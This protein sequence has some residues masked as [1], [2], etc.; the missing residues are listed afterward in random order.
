MPK[1]ATAAYQP[2]TRIERRVV[3]AA[4]A[5][6]ARA[7]SVSP[8][9]VLVA[10]GW[11]PA[12]LVDGWRQGRVD[13]LERVAAV[14]PDKLAAALEHLATW[15]ERKGLQR[16]EVADVAATRDRRTLRYTAGGAPDVERAY[17]THWIRADLSGAQRERLTRRLSQAPDL[18][19]IQPLEEW[20]CTAC[21]DTGP[22]LFMEGPGPLCLGCADMDHL[23]FLA[24]GNTA[25]TRR[26]KRASRLAAVVVRF[27]RGRK[28]YE[29][30]G[31]LVEEAALEQAE[32]HC[33][34]D[35][36]ARARRRERDRVRRSDQDLAFQASLAAEIVRLFPGC[37]DQ[38]AEAIARHAGT[39]GSGRVG[40]SAAGRA[41]AE[42]AVRLA[43]VA[44]VRHEDTDY[45][46]LLMRGAAREDARSQVQADI[47]RVLAAWQRP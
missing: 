41:L 11:L 22:F 39:R 13:H 26:A 40:R 20:A 4:E 36:D 12:S 23:V 45:D 38:R 47:D 43:V 3:D 16:R 5:M 7:T 21:G 19:V 2:R 44:S 42:A 17:R 9:D 37:P 14:G 46:D 24:A 6:I 1:E 25:L 29:R 31:L 15:A 18:V 28:R 33:L 35:E 30:Q 8:I 32:S 27:S 34:A 10:M